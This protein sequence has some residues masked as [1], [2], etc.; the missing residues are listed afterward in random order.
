MLEKV[1]VPDN[2][3]E[4]RFNICKACDQFVAGFCKQCGCF[5][6]AKTTINVASCPLGKW[7]TWNPNQKEESSGEN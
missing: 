2:I 3:K 4:E 5:M 7:G 6:K 1:F